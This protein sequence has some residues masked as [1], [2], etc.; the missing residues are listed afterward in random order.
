MRS[1]RSEFIGSMRAWLPSRRS[2]AHQRGAL[3]MRF[4]GHVRSGSSKGICSWNGTYFWNGIPDVC[5][6]WIIAA[7][8]S[9]A[10]R[11]V[12]G[13]TR[14]TPRRGGPGS[15]L[16]AAEKEEAH[17]SHAFTVCRVL[18]SASTPRDRCPHR[19]TRVPG[20]RRPMRRRPCR[21]VSDGGRRA[22]RPAPRAEAALISAASQV[23]DLSGA[24]LGEELRPTA[25]APVPRRRP[26]HGDRRAGHPSVSAVRRAG[27][28]T[29]TASS[30]TPAICSSG[31]GGHR[32]VLLRGPASSWSCA[33][34]SAPC[35]PPCR[36]SRTVETCP[37]RT[38]AARLGGC[39]KAG[40]LDVA[41]GPS[42]ASSARPSHGA[43]GSATGAASA[44][45]WS[46]ARAP[47]LGKLGH[48]ALGAGPQPSVESLGAPSTETC[49]TS[50]W[51]PGPQPWI[52][53]SASRRHRG[54]VGTRHGS[55]PRRLGRGQ[56]RGRRLDVRH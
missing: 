23:C 19:E 46:S 2:T 18:A 15:G 31:R 3:S 26:G 38:S 9:S 32:L 40:S 30:R 52:E 10:F 39:R 16:V 47:S 8:S 24:R 4:V 43:V 36:E 6:G 5:W 35:P 11:S 17:R 7:L 28:S 29:P 49:G 25:P 48:C 42:L 22:E 37:A 56:P 20:L 34:V 51:L 13:R 54:D 33:A 44:S 21:R 1:L 12:S 45:A 14:E 27:A 55:G 53:C 50:T 41:P